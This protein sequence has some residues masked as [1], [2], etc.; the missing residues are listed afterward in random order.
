MS[1]SDF[2]WL[3]EHGPEI[4][5]QYAGK[6]IA[7]HDGRIVGV[8]ETATEAAEAARAEVANGEFILEAVDRESDVIYACL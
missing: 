5:K 3:I 8:G 7:V 1:S 4:Y 2:G 6:W